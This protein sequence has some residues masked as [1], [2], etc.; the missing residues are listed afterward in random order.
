MPTNGTQAIS[1]KTRCKLGEGET[2]NL[3]AFQDSPG[4]IDIKATAD[5]GTLGFKG[6][7][8]NAMIT[9]V[10]EFTFTTFF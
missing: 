8:T 5:P 6:R 2:I 7:A 3:Q 4:D 10:K 9:L 1:L